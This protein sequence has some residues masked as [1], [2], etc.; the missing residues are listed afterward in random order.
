MS[1]IIGGLAAN[2]KIV[3]IGTSDEPIEVPPILFIQ[4]R[5][6]MVDWPSRTSIDSQ[7]ILAFSVLVGIRPMNKVYP[8]EHAAE[9]YD[10][11][12][13]GKVGF[14]CYFNR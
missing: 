7:D 4:G 8:L 13:S 3:I 1:Q 6:S 9:A 5:H 2:G 12:M 10:L 14:R 11:M